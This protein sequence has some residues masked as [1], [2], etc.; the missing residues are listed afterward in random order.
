MAISVV[1]VA[2]RATSW[3]IVQAI[4]G[5]LL[6]IQGLT[7]L[8]MIGSAFSSITALAQLNCGSKVDNHGYPKSTPSF[9]MLVIRNRRVLFQSLVCTLRSAYRV[10][11]PSLFSVLSIF[12]IFFSFGSSLI[13]IPFLCVNCRLMKQSVAPESTSPLMLA[14]LLL[15]LIETGIRIDQKCVVTVTE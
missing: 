6:G 12:H 2:F 13:P 7:D 1:V 11:N 10:I 5:F 14:I 3:L 9:P 8:M 4:I 15:V